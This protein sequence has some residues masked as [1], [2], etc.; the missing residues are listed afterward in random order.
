[1]KICLVGGYKNYPDEGMKNLGFYL[2]KELSNYHEVM[3][4]DAREN[5]FSIPSW[6][7][8]KSFNPQI[9]HV[10]MRPSLVTFGIA[11]IFKL[12]CNDAKLIV[13]AIQPPLNYFFIKALIPL[14]KL[15]LM[16][17]QSYKT[18]KIFGELGY[19]TA[20]LPSGV[21]TSRF[22]PVQS[23]IKEKIREKYGIDKEKFVV[24]HVGHI[25]KGRNLEIFKTINKSEKDVEVILIGSTNVPNFD[26]HVYNDLKKNGC[27]IWRR[28]FK[29]LEEIYQL[30][31]CYVFPTIDES[32]A[33][34]VPLSIME[35]MACN[36][37]IIST[38]F[39]GLNRIFKEGE[40]MLFVDNLNNI[41]EKIE[42]VKS[43]SL[44]INTRK[45]VLP[46]SWEKVTSDLEEIYGNL[47]SEEK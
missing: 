43:K 19:K 35:A 42:I 4:L 12:Y 18:E 32:H 40:G 44:A 29:N 25:N 31:D 14:F 36:L 30:S 34:G 9:V 13:S 5:I 33:I 8:V 7:K 23:G 3:C 1:M 26:E 17:I 21:D 39:G 2:S 24:L 16:L 27:K 20:F 6:R 22:I 47:V 45:Q 11:K 15:D 41:K 46:Y 10:F 37:P 38:K 28:Y